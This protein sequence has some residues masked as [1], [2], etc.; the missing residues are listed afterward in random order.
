MQDRPTAAELLETL[1]EYLRD[2]VLPNVTGT[3]QYHTRVALNIAQMLTREAAL[4]PPT[5]LPERDRLVALLGVPEPAGAIDTQVLSLN[6][7]LQRRLR[8]DEELD[9]RAAWAALSEACAV[10]LAISRPGYD[11]Y[12]MSGEAEQAGG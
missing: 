8:S 7:E 9:E 11:R 4:Y 5:L 3:V 6:A 2:Q 10:K 1:T 12:D